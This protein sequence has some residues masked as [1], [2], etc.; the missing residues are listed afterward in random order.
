[1][2]PAL[3]YA[4]RDR[5]E[6]RLSA[7]EE[8]AVIEATRELLA[9][10]ARPAGARRPTA[11]RRPAKRIPV[12]GVAAHGDGDVVALRMFARSARGTPF[13]LETKPE[14]LLTSEVLEAMAAGTYRAVCIAD[15]PPSA[16]SKS[17]YLVKRLRAMA[18]ELPILVGRWAP[19]ELADE[20]HELLDVRRRHA[21]R[22]RR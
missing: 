15:L 10:V 3:S 14:I 20:S 1:M 21:R 6:E 7:E 11:R 2:L 19:P 12:L 16:P 13:E 8:R 9:D 4:E 22:R 5:I 18:P 17:R